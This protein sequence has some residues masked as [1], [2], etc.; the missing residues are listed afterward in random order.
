MLTTSKAPWLLYATEELAR[1][2]EE[3]PGRDHNARILEYHAAT[4]LAATDDETP[5]CSSFVAWCFVQAGVPG[6]TSA[7]A[8]SWLEWGLPVEA[9]PGAVCVLWRTRPDSANGHVGFFLGG[10]DLHIYLLGGNQGDRVSVSA[11]PLSRVLGFRWPRGGAY[12]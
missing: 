6:Q 5:W 11:Y 8:R 1:G 10:M 9:R 12:A 4:T 3:I 2:V 7:R